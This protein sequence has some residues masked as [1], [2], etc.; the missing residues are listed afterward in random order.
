MSWNAYVDDHL[1]APFATGDTL[2]AAGIIGIDDQAMWAYSSKFPEMKPQEVKDIINAFEDSGPLAEKGLFLGGVKYLV[3]QGDPGVVI[4]GKK[5]QGGVTIKKTNMC[6]I[7]GLY[8]DPVT[9]G[10]CNSVVEKIGDYLC[11]QG[12]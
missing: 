12:F 4:R 7:I 3:V 11:E 10:Q 6:L 8:D 1:M 5:T 2:T 9:G